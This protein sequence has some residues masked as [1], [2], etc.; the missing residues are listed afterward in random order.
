MG[1]GGQRLKS[2]VPRHPTE[3]HC[4]SSNPKGSN[5]PLVKGPSQNFTL[6]EKWHE[7]QWIYS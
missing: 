6:A 2:G 7:I 4:G 1:T 5:S 3:K